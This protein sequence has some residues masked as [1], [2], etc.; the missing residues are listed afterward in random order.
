VYGSDGTS[1]EFVA[2]PKTGT[3]PTS[4]GWKLIAKVDTRPKTGDMAGQYGVSISDPAGNLGKFRYLLFDVSQTE[5]DDAFGNTFY[6]EISII[7]ASATAVAAEDKPAE[8]IP[9]LVFHSHNPDCE[10]TIDINDA[11]YLKE[12]VETKLGPTLAEWYPKIAEMIPSEGYTPPTKFLV[13]FPL[14]TGVANTS[15]PF[16]MPIVRANPTWMK[17]Q[18]NG[19]ATGALVHEEVHVIQQY[20]AFNANRRGPATRP[21][22]PQ[23]Q[24]GGPATQARRGGRRG[25]GQNTGWLTEG[26]ADYIRWWYYEPDGPRRYPALTPTTNYDGAYTITANFLHYVAEKYDKD[27]VKKLNAALREHR[28]TPDLW[29]QYTGKDVETLNEEWKK[30]LKP[31]N[32]PA[33]RGAATRPAG[34]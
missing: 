22:P 19:E 33:R 29:K 34:Q 23:T 28:Y 20:N 3:E 7:D 24:P 31:S 17:S 13:T 11:P 1:S 15:G 10:I 16:Q 21:A 25:G 2:K 12:W 18:I 14:R 32:R 9:P 26:I 30:T 6:S 5:S 27:L 8:K 4:V